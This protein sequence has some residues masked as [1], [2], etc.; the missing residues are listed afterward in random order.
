MITESLF[1]KRVWISLCL[2]LFFGRT[3]IAVDCIADQCY[4]LETPSDLTVIN[5]D[6]SSISLAWMDN[7]YFEDG[8]VVQRCVYWDC[9][10]DFS[11]FRTVALVPENTTFYNDDE[12]QLNTTYFYRVKAYNEVAE[13]GYSNIV[14]ATSYDSSVVVYCLVSSI[15]V[16]IP[17]LG[18]LIFLFFIGL[19]FGLRIWI[20]GRRHGLQR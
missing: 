14:L 11:L 3:S 10:N 18:M 20:A 2:L 15:A 8:F 4:Q 19:A 12:I 13:S 1:K 9:K 7:S 17:D 16:D 5:A 6:H